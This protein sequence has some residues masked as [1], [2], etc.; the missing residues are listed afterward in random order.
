MVIL[1]KMGT[2]AMVEALRFHGSIR[3]VT[4]NRTAG[5]WFACFCV[6]DGQPAP[7]VKDWPTIGVDVGVGTMAVCSDG[8]TAANPKALARFEAAPTIG[9]GYNP[10]HER[11]W[12]R[13]SLQ[14]PL[15]AVRQ[16]TQPARQDRQRSE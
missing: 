12:P 8:V 2:V 9:P 4:I 16:A 10:Q 14:P 5:T 11:S 1:P 3:E 13:Q 6:E 7:P 15:A